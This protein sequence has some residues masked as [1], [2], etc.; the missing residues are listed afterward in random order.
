MT[1]VPPTI[2][3]ADDDDVFRKLLARALESSGYR[4]RQV[5]NGADAIEA[6]ARA[7]DGEGEMPD[8]V[9]LDACMPEL[10]GLGILAVMRRFPRRP[11]T[12]MVTG[13][14]HGSVDVVATLR[15]ANRV[16]HKPIELD[17]LLAAIRAA[18]PT[19]SQ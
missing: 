4:V 2:L 19:S 11:P 7:A 14:A 5:S 3:L 1:R 12:F 13:F 16:F 6:L 17:E 9:V 18:L 15:G 10:S 8:L